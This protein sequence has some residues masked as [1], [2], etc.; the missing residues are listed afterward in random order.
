MMSN[1]RQKLRQGTY[2]F[3]RSDRVAFLF[4]VEEGMIELMRLQ[5]DGTPIVLQRAAPHS[6]LAEASVYSEAYHCDAV[7]AAPSVVAALPIYDFRNR[8][9]NDR[10]FSELWSSRL[11]QEVQIARYRSEILSRKTVAERLDAWLSLHGDSLPPKGDW[12]SVAIQIG[13]S[14]EALYRELSKR[15]CAR[16]ERKRPPDSTE[17]GHPPRKEGEGV[18]S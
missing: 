6:I 17:A 14:P 13:V 18:P 4:V 1:R 7:A 10:P 15:R 5:D 8:L 2:L 12:K 11:A 9:V 16:F 3:H